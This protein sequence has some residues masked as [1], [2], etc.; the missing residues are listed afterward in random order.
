MSRPK[1]T[2]LWCRVASTTSSFF[3]RLAVVA[4]T[5]WSVVDQIPM[6]HGAYDVQQHHTSTRYRH[7]RRQHS[8]GG[9][10][11]Y[12]DIQATKQDECFNIRDWC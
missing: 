5:V 11:H 10:Y 4:V 12:V 9:N 6:A 2:S 7:G 1:A 8:G 3:V